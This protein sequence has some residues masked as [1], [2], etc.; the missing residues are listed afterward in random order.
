M[1]GHAHVLVGRGACGR[2]VCYHR[3]CREDCFGGFGLLEDV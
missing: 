2:A 1:S 3:R